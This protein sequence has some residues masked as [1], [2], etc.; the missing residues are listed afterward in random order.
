MRTPLLKQVLSFLGNSK[1]SAFQWKILSFLLLANVQWCKEGPGSDSEAHESLSNFVPLYSTHQNM[2]LPGY[3][4][5]RLRLDDW[6]QCLFVCANTEACISYN[7]DR[8]SGMCEV[9]SRG[10]FDMGRKC[11]EERSLLFSQ[12]LVFH[13][14]RG[15]HCK[16]IVL[17]EQ[18]RQEMRMN[19]RRT[20]KKILFFVCN[21]LFARLKKYNLTDQKIYFVRFEILFLL[22]KN[23]FCHKEGEKP[24]S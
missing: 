1:V 15:K 22:Q 10:V 17:F 23:Y 11:H 5:Q 4:M 13:Q 8:R 3:V 19:L 6:L 18:E 21:A 24:K 16:K 7:F 20:N 12:G 9:N 14:I 2:Y